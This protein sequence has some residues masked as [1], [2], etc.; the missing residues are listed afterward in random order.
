MAKRLVITEKPSVARDIAAALG[1]FE[2][3]DEYMESDTFVLT[4]AIGHLLEL[5]EPKDYD[6]VFRSWS[7]KN[8]PII[9]EE[10]T[11]KPRDGQ[12]TRLKNIQK[13]GRRKDVEGVIN[14]CDAGREGE[15]IFRRTV[16]FTGLDAKPSERLW[17]QSMTKGAIRQAFDELRP[18]DELNPLADAAWLRAVGDWLIGMNATRALT[19]RLKSRGEQGAW[20]AGR[21]QTPTLRL[22]VE[23]ELEIMAHVP[24]PYWEIVAIFQTPEQTWE[25]RWFDPDVKS[26]GDRDIRPTR[27]FDKA[28]ADAVVA[29]MAREPKAIASETRK[30][31][32]EKPPLL[33][34][35]TALQREANKRF[36]F[37]AKRTLDAAQ[38]LY[39]GHKLITYPR[40]DSRHLPTDYGETVAGI[41]E[42]LQVDVDYKSIADQIVGE[43]PQNL[44]RILDGSLVSDHFAIV[45][46]GNESER[47]LSPDDSRIYDLIVRQF[48]AALMGPATWAV[49]ERISVVE[50]PEGP[51]RF[52]TRE[53]TLDIPGFRA[54]LVRNDDDAEKAPPRLPPLVPGQ[55]KVSDV[56]V[57]HGEATIEDKETRPRGRYSEAQLLRMMETAGEL[58]DDD[59]LVEAMNGKGL[60]TPATRADT[61]EG[62]VRKQ[63]A[64]RTSGKLAP[65]SKA[66]RLMDVLGR[67]NVDEI[68][69]PKLT[70]EL[71]HLLG[72]VEQG[73]VPRK[74][75]RERLESLTRRV[76]EA[77]VSFD[78]V[79]LYKDEPGL[80]TCPQCGEGY[81]T[82]NAWGYPCSRNTGKDGPC[83]FIVWKDRGGR[84]I[85][86]SM[87][88]K[89]V[90]ERVVGPIGGFFDRTGREGEGTLHLEYDEEKER[91][92]LRVDYG[93]ST[94]VDDEPEVVQGKLFPDPEDPDSW[95]VETNKR[96]VSERLL[97]GD[98]KKAP[99]LPKVVCHREMSPEEAALY[100]GAE[101]KTPTLDGFISRRGRPFRGALFRKPTGKHGF[102]FP[103]REPRAGA[104]KKP[105]AKKTTAK[106]PAA[107]K[108]TARKTAAKK[109]AAKRTTK[110]TPATAAKKPAT[111]RKRTT[112][113][114]TPKAGT[115]AK[116]PATKRAT[117][118]K[119]STTAVKK[120]AAKKPATRKRTTTKAT[121][122]T[123]GPA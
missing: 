19:Q 16:E 122:A 66:M 55:S 26:G 113:A 40:T 71:E 11:I 98:V 46:T 91:W 27:I 39:E 3:H 109:P 41:L 76:T 32:K 73:Q 117:T 24:R 89:L 104:K 112:K 18:G 121:P 62:L 102:E 84:F 59:D 95:I 60:G 61:I 23:R 90:D 106:K 48:M 7:V 44:E 123:D 97:S 74:D 12:K 45:P 103:P 63:Y 38:R 82:E 36:S 105:A 87:A 100:F 92:G 14:A 110:A 70:G 120:P 68:A 43:G 75:V 65:T 115:A 10:Y 118:K 108:P 69:M 28:L 77:L 93:Q 101:G 94:A 25:G 107:K 56:P 114:A 2:E 21:V 83:R 33:F 86:R 111:T 80:G 96:Y 6:K 5:S 88:K 116:K 85:D 13:L 78:H 37:S 79:D 47:S 58:I 54:A 9:P 52:R 72:Q 34:D 99:V 4:W 119:A 15:L 42:A 20:S 57:D 17:L 35:L 8:L 49:V 29:G 51:A 22:L 30:R 67:L 1:G 81:V 64:R 53:R 50:L 31:S